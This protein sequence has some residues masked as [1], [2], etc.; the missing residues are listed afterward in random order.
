MRFV[1]LAVVCLAGCAV[2][3]PA[4]VAVERQAMN[5][6]FPVSTPWVGEQQEALLGTSVAACRGQ[7]GFVGGAPGTNAVLLVTDGGAS[8]RWLLAPNDGGVTGLA[9]ACDAYVVTAGGAGVFYFTG[10]A[11]PTALTLAPA[12]SISRPPSPSQPLLVGIP[13]QSKVLLYPP[14]DGGFGTP[15]TLV[16]GAN[17]FGSVV[18]WNDT[19]GGFAVSSLQLATV[20]SYFLSNG[21]PSTPFV[22]PG[23]VG[24]GF[25][26]SLAYGD[27]HPS[28]GPELIIGAPGESKV[29]VYTALG[30]RLMTIDAPGG[31]TTFGQALTVE[32]GLGAG[33]T[34][35][36]FWVGD[37]AHDRVFRFIGDAGTEFTGPSMSAF[38]SSLAVGEPGLI[39]GAPLYTETVTHQG[40]LFVR[41]ASDP[42]LVGTVGVCS[43]GSQCINVNTCTVGMCVGGVFCQNPVS[44]GCPFACNA[45]GNCLPFDGGVDA[46]RSDAGSFDA[47]R[48]D[49]GSVDGG[50][51]DA[52]SPD[53]GTPDGGVDP[54][55]D[56]GAPDAGSSSDAGS[57]EADAGTVDGGAGPNAL[58]FTSCGCTG[59]DALPL[60]L[61]SLMLSRRR[62]VS[63]R[64]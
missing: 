51:V 15:T 47:G 34:L 8:T 14:G 53:A 11:A 5:M 41:P 13:T 23:N 22:I 48:F 52:G 6:P 32:P 38:G 55:R 42:P 44:L 60:L 29:Y 10:L 27:V 33:S 40:G 62:S 7:F 36:A 25:G 56:A 9:V 58:V 54:S 46:G 63:S 45:A 59:T 1:A 20:Y 30:M 16:A 61:L 43:A 28:S 4:E 35:H 37:P 57:S 26:T 19:S 31:S 21:L 50:P 49:A 39:V 24:V 64:R 12:S 17:D 3:A 18:K 2:D